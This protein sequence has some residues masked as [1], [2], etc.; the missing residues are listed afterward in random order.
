MSRGF[1]HDA[2]AINIPHQCAGCLALPFGLVRAGEE[3]SYQ[4]DR[5]NAVSG[6]GS[7]SHT[8]TPSERSVCVFAL[9]WQLLCRTSSTLSRSLS[10]FWSV[11]CFLG[12][13]WIFTVGVK[14]F[15]YKHRR[16]SVPS[17]STSK[18]SFSNDMPYFHR[19]RLMTNTLSQSVSVSEIVEPSCREEKISKLNKNT[20]RTLMSDISPW[21]SKLLTLKLFSFFPLFLEQNLIVLINY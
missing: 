6:A 4:S 8:H 7:L 19:V 9:F 16:F 5:P 17:I 13:S 3:C 11:G 1:S 12:W 2:T 20:H 14:I 18:M 10:V 15:I 21:K